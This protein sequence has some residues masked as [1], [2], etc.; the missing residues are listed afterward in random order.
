MARNNYWA[1]ICDRKCDHADWKVVI[2]IGSLHKSETGTLKTRKFFFSS[3][4]NYICS[5]PVACDHGAL[6]DK[7]WGRRDHFTVFL[8]SLL[9]I[10]LVYLHFNSSTIHRCACSCT[11]DSHISKYLQL[12]FMWIFKLAVWGERSMLSHRLWGKNLSSIN[13]H[14]CCKWLKEIFAYIYYQ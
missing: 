6:A 8:S 4:V 2:Y 3:N 12:I 5:L 14:F 11:C 7:S 1:C 9:H 13:V 10:L